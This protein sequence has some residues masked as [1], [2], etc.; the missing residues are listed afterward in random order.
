MYGF[1]G[2]GFGTSVTGLGDVNGNAVPDFAIGGWG[3]EVLPD[4]QSKGSVF[5]FDGANQ[6]V[7]RAVTDPRPGEGH[8]FGGEIHR[9]PD[10]TG[11]GLDE[12]YVSAPG[13]T[14]AS[15]VT[16]TN[17]VLGS[18]IYAIDPTN[19]AIVRTYQPR[20]QENHPAYWDARFEILKDSNG[21]GVPEIGTTVFATR[22]EV[23][24]ASTTEPVSVFGDRESLITSMVGIDDLNDD[25]Q[26][27]IIYGSNTR[28][29][30]LDLTKSP[31]SGA[32]AR[33]SPPVLHFGELVV[34]DSTPESQLIHVEN[35]GSRPL[36]I[37][38]LYWELRESIALPNSLRVVTAPNDLYVPIPPG[39]SREIEISYNPKFGEKNV[40]D[41]VIITNDFNHSN[42]AIIISATATGDPPV[43]IP[44][45]NTARGFTIPEED[46]SSTQFEIDAFASAEEYLGFGSRISI[47]P[48]TNGDGIEDIAVGAP[49]SLDDD[50]LKA[51]KIFV[52]DG[53]D[54][55]ILSVIDP[56]KPH[57]EDLNFGSVFTAI[58]DINGNGSSEIVVG[59]DSIGNGEVHAIDSDTNQVL[60]S[61]MGSTNQELGS[62]LD[63]LDDLNGDGIPEILEG[64]R[65]E[66]TPESATAYVVSG[67]DGSI[68][69]T[70]VLDDPDL[71]KQMFGDA[72]ASVP[73]LNGNGKMDALIG[74]PS[75]NAGI[76][77]VYV[78]DPTTGS[79]LYDIPGQN[80]AMAGRFGEEVAGVPDVDG[81]GFGDLLVS[82]PNEEV[83][84]EN[85]AGRVHVYSGVDG[86]FLYS[87]ESLAPDSGSHFGSSIAGME[88][89]NGDG[90]GDILVSDARFFSDFMTDGRVHIFSGGSGTWIQTL[91]P[92]LFKQQATVFGSAIATSGQRVL[93]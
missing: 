26:A 63:L 21:N 50:D 52:F 71:P 42:H 12:I 6:S 85:E 70:L 45:P 89:T 83:L 80:P 4:L 33:I 43:R 7:L 38:Y 67:S 16:R 49:D 27:E 18:R 20:S 8:T 37:L 61:F 46:R 82:A 91:Y 44:N 48:D 2:Y 92:L 34:G 74:A 15:Q 40:H 77:H 5:I 69:R 60:W 32:T 54:D 1:T 17:G 72:V 73:D 81:D 90:M 75:A 84:G 29:G 65:P 9:G 31:F 14:I 55:S 66:S 87:L 62:D 13:L 59:L 35:I 19:G 47:V 24:D 78:F 53:S 23:F 86:S 28:S 93:V 56:L 68:W 64:A 41:L 76:G 36:K 11:D 51:G 57:T 39:D 79:L 58:P 22:L 25:N 88:D 3:Y 10:L 30:Q